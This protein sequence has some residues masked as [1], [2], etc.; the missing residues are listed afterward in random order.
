MNSE[1]IATILVKHSTLKASKAKLE[2]M[3]PGSYVVHRSWGFGQI[4]SYS[5]ADQKL[6]IDFKGKKAHPM[7]PV[8]CV[9]SMEILPAKHILARKETDAEKIKELV[10]ND[11]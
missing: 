6:I 1:A 10:D 3:E 11:P 7:D 5:E 2:T 9:T 4:K 8:F